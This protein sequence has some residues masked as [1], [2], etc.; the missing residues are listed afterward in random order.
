MI[1]Q[2]V[3]AALAAIFLVAAVGLATLAPPN[4][5]LA[6]ALLAIDPGLLGRMEGGL[7]AH[8]P[9]FWSHVAL[10][11]LIRPAW[12]IPAGL[13]M[14]CAGVAFSLAPQRNAPPRHKRR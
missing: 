4:L 5:P 10:P 2:R 6:Q 7:R 9:W 12:L 1:K 14:V 11:V 13:G 8:A 3:P